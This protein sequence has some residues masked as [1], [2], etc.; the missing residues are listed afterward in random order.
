[1]IDRLPLGKEKIVGAI[2]SVAIGIMLYLMF[3]APSVTVFVVYQTIVLLF[4]SFV[5]LLLPAIILKRLPSTVTG[6]SMGI[7]NTGGQLAGFI[8]P[9]AIGFIVQA[10]NGSYNAAF[11]M[12]II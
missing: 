5:I 6:T 7:A 2:S 10:F 3:N 12:L 11:W 8:T 1:V 4:V 9:L